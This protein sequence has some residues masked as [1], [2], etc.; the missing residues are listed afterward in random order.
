[1]NVRKF[2]LAVVQFG[3]IAFAGQVNAD[4]L[5]VTA[6]VS[7]WYAQSSG[8]LQSGGDP[9]DLEDNLNFSEETLL[10]VYASLEHPIPIL[11]NGKFK[12]FS[13]DQ[14]GY[15]NIDTNFQGVNFNGDV[16]TN[17]DLSN[18]DFIMYYEVLDN[19][20]SIDL[21][22]NAKVFNGTLALRQ[23]NDAK[24]IVNEDIN[25]VIPMLYGNAELTLPFLQ[26]L[27]VGLEGSAMS[28]GDNTVMD[29]SAKMKFRLVFLG[30]ELGYRQLSAQLED[31]EGIEVDVDMSGPYFSLGAVF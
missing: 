11:P 17:L 16:Q 18:Y 9:V 22:L 3:L 30:M 10:M 15:G 14:V 19:Y 31:V 23:Q 27:A 6:G 8:N 29:V 28:L 24:K 1:M 12:Y 13:A 4:V 21:G 26:S 2:P 20:A 7:G 5:G 25:E